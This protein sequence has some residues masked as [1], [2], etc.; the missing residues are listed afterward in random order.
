ML[1]ICRK[2]FKRDVVEETAADHRISLKSCQFEVGELA[3]VT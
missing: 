2:I 1:V 3:S